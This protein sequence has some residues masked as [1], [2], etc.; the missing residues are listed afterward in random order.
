MLFITVQQNNLEVCIEYA[1][2][3]H[4]FQDTQT[5]E[6]LIYEATSWFGHCYFQDHDYGEEFRRG[7]RFQKFGRIGFFFFKFGRR[8]GIFRKG[9]Q[10]R[11]H[12]FQEFMENVHILIYPQFNVPSLCSFIA[13]LICLE[14]SFW[15][16]QQGFSS[17]DSFTK[18][19]NLYLNTQHAL[20]NSELNAYLRSKGS[21][22]W[23]IKKHYPSDEE[24]ADCTKI[25]LNNLLSHPKIST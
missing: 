9:E 25:V 8:F 1:V 4:I 3:K 21:N 11:F 22:D 5:V 7:R 23:F 14:H 17:N 2:N 10:Q 6:D 13:I 15:I 20:V 18:A 16:T 24:C 19:W 12:Q